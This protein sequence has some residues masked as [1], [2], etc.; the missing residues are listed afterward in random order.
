MSG[1][2]RKRGT[3]TKNSLVDHPQSSSKIDGSLGGNCCTGVDV[4]IRII[5]K[6][7]SR[8]FYR[9]RLSGNSRDPE[10]IY[11]STTSNIMRLLKIYRKIYVIKRHKIWI[12]EEMKQMIK[13]ICLSLG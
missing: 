4:H 13:K 8:S 2:A 7:L 3:D 5:E 1:N 9:K 10:L 6:I 12:F 11:T